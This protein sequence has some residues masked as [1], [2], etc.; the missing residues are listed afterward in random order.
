[1]HGWYW[2]NLVIEVIPDTAKPTILF[3]SVAF[4][5]DVSTI[6][7][8]DSAAAPLLIA[9]AAIANSTPSEVLTRE[10][11]LGIK[12]SLELDDSPGSVSNICFVRSSTPTAITRLFPQLSSLKPFWFEG[13]IRPVDPDHTQDSAPWALEI[14]ALFD[15]KPRSSSGIRA[16]EMMG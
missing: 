4:V 8:P 2:S 7:L 16:V 9:A 6:M 10:Q 13:L 1:M 5:R 3:N 15:T 11:A 12:R 14:F